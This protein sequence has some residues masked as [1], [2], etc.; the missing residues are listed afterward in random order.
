MSIGSCREIDINWQQDGFSFLTEGRAEH[1]YAWHCVIECLLKSFLITS[2]SL[3]RGSKHCTALSKAGLLLS[4]DWK[5]NG[6]RDSSCLGRLNEPWKLKSSRHIVGKR[7]PSVKCMP[8]KHEDLI[9]NDT[10]GCPLSSTHV[11]THTCKCTHSHSQFLI[12][13]KEHLS[14]ESETLNQNGELGCISFCDSRFHILIW[15]SPIEQTKQ[16]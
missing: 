2:L 3:R 7:V 5:Q 10:W 14:L 8:C 16:W 4:G 13:I 9:T 15:I 12:K 6:L 11:N 1:S